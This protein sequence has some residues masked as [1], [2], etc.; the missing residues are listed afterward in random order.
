MHATRLDG[1]ALSLAI[2]A[3]IQQTIQ[4]QLSKGHRAPGLTVVLVGEDPASRIYVR[5]KQVACERVGIQSTRLQNPVTL[6][7]PA[8]LNLITELNHDTAVDGILVQ[9]PLPPHINVARVLDS[10]D[11]AKDIDGFHP[12]NLGKLAQGR[13]QFRACTPYGVMMLLET[14]KI[15]L[16]GLHAVIVGASNIVGKPM[17][18][19]L[20]QAKCTVTLCHIATRNLQQHIQQA[21]LLVSAIGK[22]N[23]IQSDWIKIGA[24]VIDVGINRRSDGAITGDIDFKTA[25][26]RAQAITPVPG[27]VGPMTVAMLLKNTLQ[28]YQA[29]LDCA[30]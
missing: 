21:D 30:T 11:P 19:E 7:E 3:D 4:Q 5:R 25:E 9:L 16:S 2:E 18:L 12:Q 28:S 24:I 13:P 8:L 27:G 22:P 10:I 6:S 1:K 26:M 23:I 17:A 15:D 29:H 14:L 20:L